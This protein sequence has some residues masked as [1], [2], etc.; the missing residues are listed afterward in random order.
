MKLATV[1][2]DDSVLDAER[3]H[4]NHEGGGYCC[5]HCLQANKHDGDTEREPVV[6]DQ[7]GETFV[8]W[9]ETEIRRCSGK[10]A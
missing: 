2:D 8:V 10:L 9:N 1:E 6:C 3:E 4:S 5:P 7:C